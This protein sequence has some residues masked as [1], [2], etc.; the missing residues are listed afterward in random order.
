MDRVTEKIWMWIAWR[1]PHKLVYWCA[2][3]VGAH[4]TT[5]EHE[6]QIV[7]DLTFMDAIKR[8]DDQNN[9]RSGMVYRP[10]QS[11]T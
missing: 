8:W 1:L 5:G 9:G 4:A 2:I 11:T 3:R 7:P 10:D 6:Y